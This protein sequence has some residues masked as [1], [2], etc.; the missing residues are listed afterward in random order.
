M[1]SQKLQKT[2]GYIIVI[3][4]IVFAC[5]SFCIMLLGMYACQKAAELQDTPIS[6][7]QGANC[8]RGLGILLGSMLGFIFILMG[9]FALA[10]SLVYLFLGRR[11]IYKNNYQKGILIASIVFESIMIVLNTDTLFTFLFLEDITPAI[12]Y[13]IL[14]IILLSQAIV[15]L[16]L[17]IKT[18]VKH[19]EEVLIIKEA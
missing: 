9:V 19:K 7:D 18:M 5:I 17:V 16:V 4:N 14:D 8:A 13:A 1:D 12:L 6:P 10:S 11:L 15:T 2:C 3:K